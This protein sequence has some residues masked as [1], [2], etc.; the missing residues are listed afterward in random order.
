MVNYRP[1]KFL[2][3]LAP[4]QYA[5]VSRPSPAFRVR[6]WLRETTQ[7]RP[8]SRAVPLFCAVI[9]SLQERARLQYSL[10]LFSLLFENAVAKE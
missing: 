8:C 5:R 3:L 9:A 1:Q 2:G 4:T 6:V 7:V 10:K